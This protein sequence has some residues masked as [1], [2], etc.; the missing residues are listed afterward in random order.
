MIVHYNTYECHGRLWPAVN[1]P[2]DV[3]TRI[4]DPDRQF[5]REKDWMPHVGRYPDLNDEFWEDM[6]TDFP[7]DIT[8]S[9]ASPEDLE[10][11]QR[12][13]FDLIIG[14]IETFLQARIP[15]SCS[16]TLMAGQVQVNHT[17]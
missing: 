15:P 5:D 3:A 11:K 2:I 4:E 1:F 6:K 9:S 7:A 13:L 8:A 10:R 16:L 12:Q 14:I 17:S